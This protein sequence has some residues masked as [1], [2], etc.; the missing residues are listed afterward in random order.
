MWWLLTN[1]VPKTLPNRPHS[2]SFCG[3]MLLNRKKYKV[4]ERATTRNGTSTTTQITVKGINQRARAVAADG[5]APASGSAGP[6]AGPPGPPAAPAALNDRHHRE[7]RAD[8]AI[9]AATTGKSL[10]SVP[11]AVKAPLNRYRRSPNQ[12][13]APTR[14]KMPTRSQLMPA[15]RSSAGEAAIHQA[16]RGL[17]RRMRAIEPKVAATV[18]T[19]AAANHEAGPPGSHDGSHRTNPSST[20]YSILSCT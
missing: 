14:N 11:M 13:T 20:G 8:T 5:S 16:E 10:N 12:T 1:D 15:S 17:C 9:G 19:P 6:V 18:I 4:L 3:R 2:E 7:A